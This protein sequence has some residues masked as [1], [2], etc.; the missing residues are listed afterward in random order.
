MENQFLP[1]EEST[2]LKSMGYRESCLTF[3][4]GGEIFFS[5]EFDYREHIESI[6]PAPLY[7]QV[8]SWF[9]N[10][11]KLYCVI[12]PTPQMFWT[13]K[14]V[15][16]G[17]DEIETPPYKNVNAYDYSTPEEAELSCIREMINAVKK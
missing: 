13:F 2:I 12:I 8:F 16:L 15:N 17:N 9:L 1:I 4:L 3:Y 11:H 5:H 7:R 14:I 6:I 10:N